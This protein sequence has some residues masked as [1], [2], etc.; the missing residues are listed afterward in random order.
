VIS[1]LSYNFV[2]PG[3]MAVTAGHLFV[4][5]AEGGSITEFPA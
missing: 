3:A 4:A 5:N 2:C 1:S